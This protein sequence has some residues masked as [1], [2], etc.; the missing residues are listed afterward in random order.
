MN[1][2]P[3]SGIDYAPD[4]HGGAL[5][6]ALARRINATLN[7][8]VP[9]HERSGHFF[10][11]IATTQTFRGAAAIGAARVYAESSSTINDQKSTTDTAVSDI[12]R[13][14]MARGVRG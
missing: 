14:R 10:G 13:S 11:P 4:P 1:V 7:G 9:I 2:V 6:S 12:F 5:F 8:A 3:V